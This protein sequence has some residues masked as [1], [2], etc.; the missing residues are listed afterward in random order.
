MKLEIT[1]DAVC[2]E[3]DIAKSEEMCFS[4]PWSQKAVA[5]F[6][7]YDCNGA[8]VCTAD[9]RFAG[10]VTYSVVCD[11]M[12][13]ANVATLPCFRRMGVGSCL[14]EALKQKAKSENVHV[15]TLEVR[16]Q[17]TGAVALYEKC[18]FVSVGIRKNFYKKPDDNAVLMNLELKN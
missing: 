5:D 15:I 10:Y 4:E 3:E 8:L 9:G 14:I 11:E 1:S 17:N 13:I 6:L 16:S 7:E 2:Y 18:G 12:Q